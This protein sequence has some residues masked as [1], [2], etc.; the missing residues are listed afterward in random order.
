M[1][2]KTRKLLPDTPTDHL[3]KQGV[4]GNMLRYG[5]TE[6]AKKTFRRPPYYKTAS[7]VRTVKVEEMGEHSDAM[8]SEVERKETD[9]Q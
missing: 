2:S 3:T 1:I 5:V 6:E 8:S 9:G 7:E 4:Y